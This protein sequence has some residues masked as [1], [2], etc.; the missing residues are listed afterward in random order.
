MDNTHEPPGILFVEYNLNYPLIFSNS[1]PKKKIFIFYKFL[2]L[3]K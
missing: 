2:F 1:S 3:T